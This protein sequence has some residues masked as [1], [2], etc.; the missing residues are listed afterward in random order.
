MVVIFSAPPTPTAAFDRP[1]RLNK[2]R[3]EGVIKWAELLDKF[4]SVQEKARR[5]NRQQSQAGDKSPSRNEATES[6]KEKALPDVPK[7]SVR[8]SS[9]E[10]T[11]RPSQPTHKPKSSLGNF[12]RL[13]SS[14]SG[15][16]VKK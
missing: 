8:P 6:S 16:K 7:Q 9:A 10:S 15:K 3:E 5:T 2:Q 14:V 4:K 1:G 13:T 12:S 11:T